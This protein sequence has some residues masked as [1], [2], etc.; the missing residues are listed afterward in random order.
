MPPRSPWMK[1]RILGFQRRVWCPKCTPDSSSSLMPT[2]AIGVLPGKV[3]LERRRAV[4]GGGR[5]RRAR[6][7]GPP[8]PSSHRGIA[9]V[10][11]RKLHRSV[12]ASSPGPPRL[13]AVRAGPPFPYL[14]W[15]G[16]CNTACGAAGMAQ[17]AVGGGGTAAPAALKPLRQVVGERR[18]YVDA[19]GRDRMLEREPLG[20]Q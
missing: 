11:G 13:G 12:Y 9:R 14:R 20:V 1:R 17:R 3:D 2:S 5:T 4:S 6:R 18:A 10:G 19:L 15:S 8:S 7:A 16:P